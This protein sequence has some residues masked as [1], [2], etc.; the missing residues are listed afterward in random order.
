MYNN[1]GLAYYHKK[2]YDRAIADFEAALR[3]DPNYAAAKNNLE[4]AQKARD[5]RNG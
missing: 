1:S 2:D 3:L 5:I 4:K